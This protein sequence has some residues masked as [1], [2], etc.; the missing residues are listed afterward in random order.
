MARLKRDN[1]TPYLLEPEPDQ[2]EAKPVLLLMA[3]DER[4]RVKPSQMFAHPLALE[5]L[6]PDPQGP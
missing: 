2:P 5:P 6:K 4:K 1:V 3:R